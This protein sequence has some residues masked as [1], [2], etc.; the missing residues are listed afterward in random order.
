MLNSM[1][2]NA[3]WFAGNPARRWFGKRDAIPARPDALASARSVG[4]VPAGALVT[5]WPTKRRAAV[6]IRKPCAVELIVLMPSAFTHA[7]IPAALHLAFGRDV[8]GRRLLVLAM[9]CAVA[10]D[11]DVVPMFLLSIP[12]ESQ[13]GHRGF[14]HSL[15][16][17]AALATLAACG[18]CQLQ[19]RPLVVWLVIFFATASH[20]LLDA[21]TNGGGGVALLWPFTDARIASPWRPIAVSP[22]GIRRFFS[23][24]GVA[25]IASEL[26]WVWL[27]V[28]AAALVWRR[29]ARR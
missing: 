14:T 11:L 8:I 27:P 15:S 1:A 25:V 26:V 7:L 22:L 23:E 18:W 5:R 24:R 12:Y 21:F 29:V 20:A 17:A 9:F 16:F 19:A 2:G 6:I 28:L 10:P 3:I 13:W 4:D